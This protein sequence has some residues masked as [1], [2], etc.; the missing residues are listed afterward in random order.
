MTWSKQSE[1]ILTNEANEFLAE[2][3]N[4]SPYITAHTSG[5][6]GTPK[7]IHLLKSDMQLSAQATNKAFG[8]TNSSVLL[9][10]LSAR[11]IAGK[12]MIVRA[13][14]ADCRL[15]VQQ[16]SG[17]NIKLDYG[18]AIDLLAVVPTQC[19]ALISNADAKQWLRCVIV[20]G[21]AVSHDIECR[22]AEMPWRSFATYGMTETCSH[23]ALRQIKPNAHHLF[24]AMPGISFTTDSRNCLQIHSTEMSFSELTTN[25]VVDLISPTEFTWL[26]RFDNV[27][28]SGGLKFMPETLEK[29]LEGVMPYPFYIVGRQDAHWGEAVTIVVEC[30]DIANH[31][32]IKSHIIDICHKHLPRRACPKTVEI[33]PQ[34]PRT[35]NGK[36]RRL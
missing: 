28:N 19:E 4:D 35:A 7:A 25:D 30:A 16:P 9:L 29:A 11:Y 36:V 2:W 18:V 34:L 32:A 14:E 26:G 31:D 6:T 10:P 1:S 15:I 17:S 8:I 27:I 33:V 24:H 3:F 5:S 22:L 12:M 13:I 21:G 23:V 20:G